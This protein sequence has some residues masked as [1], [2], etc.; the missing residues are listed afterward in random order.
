MHTIG[1]APLQVRRVEDVNVRG[2]GHLLDAAVAG[3]VCGAFVYVS[4][5]NAVFHGQSIHAGTEEGLP[6]PLPTQHTDAYSRTKAE[7]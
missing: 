5:Y 2:T 7:V 3:G 1:C 4:S 6:P